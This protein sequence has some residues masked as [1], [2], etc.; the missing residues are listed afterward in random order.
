M[1]LAK[2]YGDVTCF[3]NECHGTTAWMKVNNCHYG[4]SHGTTATKEDRIGLP[5]TA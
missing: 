2:T 5:H 3:S 4:H 1:P